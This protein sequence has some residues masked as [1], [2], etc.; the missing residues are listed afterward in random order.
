[1]TN[2]QIGYIFSQQRLK[3][4]HKWLKE[5]GH[6][7]LGNVYGYPVKNK[8]E[9]NKVMAL[10]SNNAPYQLRHELFILEELDRKLND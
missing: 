6:E 5:N 9:S 10:N 7:I 8:N 4:Y 3:E 1:M 2:H